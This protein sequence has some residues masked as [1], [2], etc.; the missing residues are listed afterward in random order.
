MP[1][2]DYRDDV[3]EIV[4]TVEDPVASAAL[5]GLMRALIKAGTL[6][7][8]LAEVDWKQVGFPCSTLDAW[9]ADHCKKDDT[10]EQS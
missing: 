9:W 5:C 10:K 4:R 6:E 2:Y 8:V 7:S 1:C 3:R